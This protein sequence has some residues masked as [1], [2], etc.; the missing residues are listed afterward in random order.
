M[1]HL[2]RRFRGFQFDTEKKDKLPLE[3]IYAFYLFYQLLKF[4]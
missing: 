1:S 4:P 2:K 3:M